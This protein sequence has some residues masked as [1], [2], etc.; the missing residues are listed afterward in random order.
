MS[1]TWNQISGDSLPGRDEPPHAIGEDLGAAAGKRAEAGGLELAQHLL[2]REPGERRHVVD[3]GRRVALEV[4]V[5]QRVVQRRDRVAVE[6]EVDVRVL[7]VDHVDLGEPG[8]LALARA[9][10]RRAPRVVNVYAC[11]CF[12]VAAK[13][14]NLH[15]TRQTF[16]W[17][18]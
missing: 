1:W 12:R 17:F 16:V 4:H 10:P 2:V 7:A 13:A 3:L 11:S 8:D 14:Q 15:F 5:G 9:R 18:T 6:G